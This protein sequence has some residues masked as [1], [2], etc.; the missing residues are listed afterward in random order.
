MYFFNILFF[1]ISLEKIYWNAPPIDIGVRVG[2]NM[3]SS[4]LFYNSG[5]RKSSNTDSSFNE[6]SIWH[7]D[8]LLDEDS[9]CDEDSLS[10][11][12][13]LFFPCYSSIPLLL[14]CFSL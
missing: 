6:E 12:V 3:E 5:V 13:L 14:F 11:D 1:V 2:S 4:I 7:Q 9:L 8:L 10:D